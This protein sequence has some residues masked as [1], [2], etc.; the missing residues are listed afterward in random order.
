[1]TRTADTV[2]YVDN[3]NGYISLDTNAVTIDST[4][5]TNGV[6]ITDA[7]EVQNNTLF[8]YVKNT[9]AG[10]KILY[11]RPGC[12]LSGRTTSAQPNALTGTLAISMAQNKEYI[13]PIND[14]S[15]FLQAANQDYDG[16][17]SGTYT[18]SVFIDFESGF[19]G[20]I[21][22]FSYRTAFLA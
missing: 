12:K 18:G 7:S 2:N 17:T 6:A 15:R 14:L 4:L 10:A 3:S 20:T 16:G 21:C 5:V 8:L 1:M 19:T 9:Y 11:I 22:P 13:I